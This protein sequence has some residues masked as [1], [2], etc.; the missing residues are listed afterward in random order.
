MATAQQ[1]AMEYK[2]LS[3]KVSE[4]VAE[5]L[6]IARN[7]DDVNFVAEYNPAFSKCV[8]I[9]EVNTRDRTTNRVMSLIGDTWNETYWQAQHVVDA[10]RIAGIRR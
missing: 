3:L 4:V 9:Y 1:K 7:D 6:T 2:R 5:M 10:F 8:D